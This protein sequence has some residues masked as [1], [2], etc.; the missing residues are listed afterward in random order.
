MSGVFT[1]LS[2]LFA[3][4]SSGAMAYKNHNEV[5]KA[6]REYLDSKYNFSAQLRYE[7]NSIGYD[8]D[9]VIDAIKDD[10]PNISECNAYEVAFAAIAKRKMEEET[11]YRYEQRGITKYFDLEKYATDKFKI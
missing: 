9:K 10:Y 8:L 7:R 6:N 1:F 4:G 3:L 2:S 11:N 5:E